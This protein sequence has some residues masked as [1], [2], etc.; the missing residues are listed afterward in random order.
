MQPELVSA[1]NTVNPQNSVAHSLN[2]YCNLITFI[3]CFIAVLH[4]RKGLFSTYLNINAQVLPPLSRSVI[5][6]HQ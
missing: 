4:S 5:I 6:P 3:A 1:I 2:G